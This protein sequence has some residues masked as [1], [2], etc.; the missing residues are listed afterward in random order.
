MPF[1]AVRKERKESLPKGDE[2]KVLPGKSEN[3][4]FTVVGGSP[5]SVCGSQRGVLSLL[6]ENRAI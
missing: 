4:C 5:L 3:I 2:A 6:L 1:A